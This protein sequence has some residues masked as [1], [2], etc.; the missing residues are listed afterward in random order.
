MSVVSTIRVASLSTMAW[1]AVL[2]ATS[3]AA[4][5]DPM[6]WP[7]WRGPQQ[8]RVSTEKGL[9]EKW[10]PDGGPGSN[11]LWK[12]KAFAG[13]ALRSCCTEN[14]TRSFTID[15]IRRT[16]ARKLL[17]RRGH[18]QGA[19]GTLHERVPLRCAGGPLR[20]V[21]LRRRP[22]DGTNLRT[23]CLRILLLPGRGHGQIG[24]GPQPARRVR[25]D[26]DLRRANELSSD[27]RR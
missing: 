6:D 3:G 19:V 18:R 21:E 15:Q 7:N 4:T 11:L 10:D 1:L 25:F 23:E 20:L 27:L 5:P 22:G 16:R 12:K 9:V 26:L 24:V 13:G 17:R 8:N 14:S 2:V